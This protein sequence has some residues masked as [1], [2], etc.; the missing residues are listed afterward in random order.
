MKR[1][2]I[3][4]NFCDGFRRRSLDRCKGRRKP[5]IDPAGLRRKAHG[6][7]EVPV[8]VTAISS[9][10]LRTPGIR[11]TG[12]VARQVPEPFIANWGFR[13]PRMP[14]YTRHRGRQQRPGH[15][16][17]VDDVNYRTH[18]AVRHHNLFGIERIGR[19]LRGRRGRCTEGTAWR[20]RQYHEKPDNEFHYG[21]EQTVGNENHDDAYYALPPIVGDK[22][23]SAYPA[24]QEQMDGCCRTILDNKK[25]G[26]GRRWWIAA[27]GSTAG[28]S[29]ADAHGQ[30]GCSANAREKVNDGVF[31]QTDM[32]QPTRTAPRL[33]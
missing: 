14:S 26:W 4:G 23:F 33:L 1:N 31:C 21:L 22:L 15:R 11:S 3:R 2:G 32:D 13:A 5:K 16:L 12:D 6:V 20:R 25:V 29:C 9:S 30:A 17:Y 18:A 28:C 8:S 19:A 24:R 10:R 27:G 7:Q